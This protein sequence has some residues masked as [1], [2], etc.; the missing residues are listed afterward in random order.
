MDGDLEHVLL[1][2]QTDCLLETRDVTL[3]G[4]VWPRSDA[5]IGTC[6]TTLALFDR[7]FLLVARRIG[8]YSAGKFASVCEADFHRFTRTFWFDAMDGNGWLIL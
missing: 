3:A 5:A 7:V 1:T 6:A 2:K 8:A 4:S